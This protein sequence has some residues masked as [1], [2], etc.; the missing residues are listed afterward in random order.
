M[1]KWEVQIEM[2]VH[3]DV[4]YPDLPER[5]EL[6]NR[7]IDACLAPH[8]F[9]LNNNG[10]I[11]RNCCCG[12]RQNWKYNRDQVMDKSRMGSILIDNNCV[13]LADSLGYYVTVDEYN[14]STVEIK[15]DV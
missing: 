5:Y 1:C 15:N 9:K 6:K 2:P 4:N 8:V 14:H 11:T 10:C 13:R 12:H 7:M 3:V